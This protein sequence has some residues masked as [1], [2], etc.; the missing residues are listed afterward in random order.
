MAPSSLALSV[1]KGVKN[2]YACK[3]K[4]IKQ[5][6]QALE[7]MLKLKQLPVKLSL[8]KCLAETL[9]KELD[10]NTLF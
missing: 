2:Y 1:L 10:P 7:Q 6:E 9:S 8:T 4:E 3:I 5:V